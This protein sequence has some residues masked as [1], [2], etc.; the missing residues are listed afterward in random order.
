MFVLNEL[1][2]TLDVFAYDAERGTMNCVQTAATL[3]N[4]YVGVNKAAAIDVHPTG[5]YVYVSNRG[6]NLITVFA[7]SSRAILPEKGEAGVV[8]NAV[9]HFP[10]GGDFPRH[11][12]LTPDGRYLLSC[13]KKTHAL[14]VFRVDAETGKLTDTGT[15]VTIPWCCSVAF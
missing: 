9:Q 12:G 4:D 8:L 7:I 13:N 3:P 2:C 15:Q 5:K 11:I 1:N 6:A 14:C 10:S